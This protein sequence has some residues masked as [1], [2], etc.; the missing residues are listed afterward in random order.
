MM[1]QSLMPVSKTSQPT[2]LKMGG[3]TDTEPRG[4]TIEHHDNQETKEE[5]KHLQQIKFHK[6]KI[7]QILNL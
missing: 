1:P 7:F 2:D 4:E 3:V 5:R 6:M